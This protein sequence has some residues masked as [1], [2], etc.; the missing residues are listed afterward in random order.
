MSDEELLGAHKHDDLPAAFILAVPKEGEGTEREEKGDKD[1]EGVQKKA[2]D[3]FFIKR[4]IIDTDEMNFLDIQIAPLTRDVPTLRV[5]G[6]HQGY[7]LRWSPSVND[8]WQYGEGVAN[9]ILNDIA[10]WL[11]RWPD[12]FM[13]P[14]FLGDG[15]STPQTQARNLTTVAVSD[16]VKV[17]GLEEFIE[18][19]VKGLFAHTSGV[20]DTDGEARARFAKQILLAFGNVGNVDNTDS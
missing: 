4:E 12:A 10:K 2:L 8:L 1:E 14:L 11:A 15:S 6:M 3:Y 18:T 20:A 19:V 17:I 5:G 16:G 7:Q 13:M 9:F